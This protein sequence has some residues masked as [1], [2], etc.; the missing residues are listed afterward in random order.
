MAEPQKDEGTQ[1]DTTP[2]PDLSNLAEAWDNHSKVRRAVMEHGQLLS[3][4]DPTRVGV[5]S[6]PT[7]SRNF[8]VVM[9]LLK[10]YLPQVP[11]GK[12]AYV[13]DLKEQVGFRMTRCFLWL[14]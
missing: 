8:D 4:P 3:W 11:S 2:C 13:D 14:M 9:E 7:L 10:I 5:V 6:L 12:T 1:E